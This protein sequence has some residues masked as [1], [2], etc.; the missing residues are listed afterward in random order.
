MK[1]YIISILLGTFCVVSSFANNNTNTLTRTDANLIGHVIEVSTGEHLP[2]VLIGIKGTNIGT[3]TDATGHYFLKHIPEG[4]ITVIASFLGY[5]T[6][7]KEITVKAGSTIELNFDLEKNSKMLKE[8][9]VSANRNETPRQLAPTLVSVLPTKIFE[10]TNSATLADGLNFQPGLRVENDCQNCG[11]TQVR[12]NG[13]EGAYSQ[14]LID[15]RPIFSSLAGVY[16]LE[17]IPATMI[18]RV[19]VVRGGGSALFGA[20]AIAGTIN[21]I[22]KDPTRNSASV[23]HNIMSIGGSGSFDNNTGFNVSMVSDNH[24]MGIMAFGQIR[25]RSAYDHDGDDFSELAVMDSRTLGFRSFLKTSTRSRL[26]LEYHNTEEYRRGGD[27]LDREPYEAYI[28]EQAETNIHAGSLKY[29]WF[30][31]STKDRFN[32]YLATQLTNRKS[33]YG[34]GTPF[35]DGGTNSERLLSYGR[36][37]DLTYSLGGQ[38]THEFDQLLFMPSALTAGVEY[39]DDDLTD[40]SDFR[41]EAIDQQ[42]N[43]KSVYAQNEWKTDMWS[44]LVGARVDKH[45]L[46]NNAVVS[47]RANIRYNPKEN[48]NIR[49]S[50]GKGFRAPQVFDEDLHV[51]VASGK[52][53]ITV[54][55]PNLKE[56][57]SHSF[58]ASVDWYIPIGN[59][60]QINF[61][62]DGFLTRLLDPFAYVSTEHENV[63]NKTIVNEAGAKVYGA[64]FEIRSSFNNLLQFQA[65][66][67]IQESI[68]DKAFKWSDDDTDDVKATRKMLRTPNVYGYMIATVTPIKNFS[69]SLSGKYTGSMLA[70]HASGYIDTNR[71]EKTSDFFDFNLKVSYEFPLYNTSNIELNAGVQNIFNSYQNDFDKGKDRDSGYIYGP[72]MPRS[73]FAG[74]KINF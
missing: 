74:V 73:Y 19:E 63:I 67:T 24:K 2:Y 33:Y 9:V 16:G 36:T 62:I 11:F 7:E 28:A 32:V 17:Q 14:I 55:D 50:Y 71:T 40:K 44:F 38:Y 66:L 22:T 61:L 18:E 3:T 31:P 12:M 34:G 49:L 60:S 29:D 56:E 70:P 35:F 26:T 1:Q 23:S 25:H 5:K 52:Q 53:V 43:T 57:T 72:G 4:K 39:S 13:L 10:L 41:E 42:V 20:S 21:I 6:I 58:S 69:T 48:I 68:Y 8:V 15:S 54:H 30:T 59:Q 65:G 64:S 45:S 37:K 47:P 51:E 27:N 46:L